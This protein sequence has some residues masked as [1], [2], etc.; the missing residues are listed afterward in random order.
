MN[1]LVIQNIIAQVKKN[2]GIEIDLNRLNFEDK[3]VYDYI[4]T[5]KTEGIFQIESSGMQSFMKELKPDCLEDIIAGISLYR[6][7]PMDFIPRYVKG[8]RDKASIV[9]EC[10]QLKDILSPTYGC[11]VYQE[12]VMQIV[13][14]LAGYTM[15][16]SDLVRR[17][18]S[19]KK[20]SVMEEE[21]HNFV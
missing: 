3:N 7:G 5:G 17:A 21:R 19:K 14:E 20:S 18:M 1:L 15:G 13:R 9:Y 8:K 4:S 11:I 10:P 16:R 12:Q 2:H 6:P